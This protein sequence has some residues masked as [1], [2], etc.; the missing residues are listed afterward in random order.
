MARENVAVER[1][2][3]KKGG[4]LL[5]EKRVPPEPW[6]KKSAKRK[7]VVQDQL[8]LGKNDRTELPE[9]DWGTYFLNGG[10]TADRRKK[11]YS[12]GEKKSEVGGRGNEQ[13]HN[14]LPSRK[15]YS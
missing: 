1:G 8:G 4:L 10:I 9:E 3:G 11:M 13:V 12:G 15:I 7:V 5:G 2:T 6:G 14:L